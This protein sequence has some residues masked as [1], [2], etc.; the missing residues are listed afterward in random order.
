MERAVAER[1]GNSKEQK[2]SV[3]PVNAA[4]GHFI[5][6][7]VNRKDGFQKRSS[8]FKITQDTDPS[9]QVQL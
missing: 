9:S 6:G 3:P 8:V 5:L 4:C 1:K 7:P 2:S